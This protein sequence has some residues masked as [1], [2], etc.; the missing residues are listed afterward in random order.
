[1]LAYSNLDQ[2]STF[3]TP[4]GERPD[5]RRPL[6]DTIEEYLRHTGHADLICEAVDGLVGND[7]RQ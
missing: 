5:L 6:I 3:A 7:P 2:P 4:S 1:M